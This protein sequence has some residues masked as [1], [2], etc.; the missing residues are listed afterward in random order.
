MRLVRIP[1]LMAAAVA[2]M[3]ALAACSGPAPSNPAL[4]KVAPAQVRAPEPTYYLAL[5]DSL[6]Q[7]VQPNAAGVSVMTRD[8][9]PWSTR[10][11][12]PAAPG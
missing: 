2:V 10:F 5:G 12:T 3:A 4:A 9:Y 11:C 1:R 6:A 7:G 8:G